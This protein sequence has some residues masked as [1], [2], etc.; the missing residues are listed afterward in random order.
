MLLG[1]GKMMKDLPTSFTASMRKRLSDAGLITVQKR[2]NAKVIY[3]NEEKAWHWA[4][5]NLDGE[6]SKKAQFAG[7]VLQEVFTRLKSYMKTN[8][9]ALS[10]LLPGN[11]VRHDSTN[12]EQR[13]RDAYLKASQG[14]WNIRVRLKD[15]KKH[16]RDID[17]LTIDR[18]LEEFQI[19]G[20]IILYPFDDPLENSPEDDNAAVRISGVNYTIIY[21]QE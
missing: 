11:T 7:D 12:I 18:A 8:D 20:K 2:G 9:V 17:S 13:I 16:L 14:S 15:L 6:I 19:L 1:D 10:E 21:I 4:I 3:L 5:E